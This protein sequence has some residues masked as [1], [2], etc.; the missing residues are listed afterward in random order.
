MISRNL[1]GGGFSLSFREYQ[2]ITSEQR[3]AAQ[4][5]E[6]D[7]LEEEVLGVLNVE[8]LDWDGLD[9]PEPDPTL[10]PEP[11]SD[12]IVEFR[13]EYSAIWDYGSED[14]AL[15]EFIYYSYEPYNESSEYT[16]QYQEL[17][18]ILE[19]DVSPNDGE[20]LEHVEGGTSTPFWGEK[21][22]H[23]VVPPT[24]QNC[25]IMCNK[26]GIPEDKILCQDCMD[27]TDDSDDEREARRQERIVRMQKQKGKRVTPS[28]EKQTSQEE[29]IGAINDDSEP[30]EEF[31]QMVERLYA[32]TTPAVIPPV[33]PQGSNT[34]GQSAQSPYRPPEDS[35][36]IYSLTE[37]EEGEEVAFGIVQESLHMITHQVIGSW[38]A[39]I[40]MSDVQKACRHQ[41]QDHQEIEAPGED[42]CLWCKHHINIRTRS[43]C[44]ACL[45]T[46]CNFCSLRYLGREVPPKAQERPSP[47]PDQS[48]L[49]QQQQ[50]YM[51]WADQ[52]RA[53]LKKEVEDE[54]RRGQLLF[55]AEK[56]RSERLG[57]E[58]AQQKLRIESME[59]EQ[60]LKDDLHAHTEKD[61]QKEIR[62][63]RRQLRD[64]KIRRRSLRN[65]KEIRTG[66]SEE[67]ASSEGASGSE[68]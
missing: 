64:E 56:R 27:I 50:L 42:T 60:R 61:L 4:H 14:E 25:C 35:D 36:A 51:N 16:K 22:E 67:D 21:E 2:P 7:S 40:D 30:W 63:L 53:R 38:R 5:P 24:T 15:L 41:W 9:F 65:G 47:F 59:E 39:H 31:E 33:D 29:V 62:R 34:R 6:E 17:A 1:L 43:H 28:T 3:R 19:N 37:G 48:A 18:A 66:S 11:V 8:V 54:K 46:T 57:E 45:L 58:I 10:V 68:N 52:D 13:R 23:E 12:E 55:E 26:K 44:P 49:I 32:Q 20:G